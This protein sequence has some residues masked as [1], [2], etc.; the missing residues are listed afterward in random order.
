MLSK[1]YHTKFQIQI[2]KRELYIQKYMKTQ[3]KHKKLE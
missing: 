1:T 2:I 3:G